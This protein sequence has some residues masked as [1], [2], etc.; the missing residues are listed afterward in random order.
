MPQT[1]IGG[2]RDEVAN[3]SFFFSPSSAEITTCY[4]VNP[5]PGKQELEKF[6]NCL[7]A[8]GKEKKSFLRLPRSEVG[9][10]KRGSFGPVSPPSLLRLEFLGCFAQKR[11][12]ARY[13][14]FQQ[15]SARILTLF[16]QRERQ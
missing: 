3:I 7:E 14:Y 5:K 1:K 12:N 8:A 11:N 16:N 13:C 9:G 4:A 6:N 2:P 15:R 10:H